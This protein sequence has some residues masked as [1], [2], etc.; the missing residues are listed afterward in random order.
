MQPGSR[1][2]ITRFFGQLHVPV[3]PIMLE[4]DYDDFYRKQR[5]DDEQK[6]THAPAPAGPQFDDAD[7]FR[8]PTPP[9]APADPWAL[10][11]P[12]GPFHHGAPPALPALKDVAKL[13]LHNPFDHYPAGA[14]GDE[15]RIEVDYRSGGDQLD[16]RVIQSNVMANN[17]EFGSKEVT[18]W[19][20]HQIQ[21]ITALD[22][23]AQEQLPAAYAHTTVLSPQSIAD[24]LT[25]LG[26]HSSGTAPDTLQEGRTLDGQTANIDDVLPTAA[27]ANAPTIP[28][29]THEN[30]AVVSTGGNLSANFGGYANEHGVIG[31][32]VVLGDSYKSDAIVQTN[33]LVD[34]SAIE[35][36]TP[37]TTI[38]T[39]GD[40]AS[41]AAD[42]IH[43][44]SDNPY[45]M[46]AF[47]GLHWHV[48]TIQGDYYNVSLAI[49]YNNLSDQDRVSQTATDH[50]KF[51]ETGSN[52]QGNQLVE[53]NLDTTHYDLVIVTGNYYAA[54][55]IFQTNVL[56]NNDLV[57]LN[58][59][60]GGAGH[61]TV[62]T[63]ANWLSNYAQIIDY[64]GAG[65]AMTPEMMAVASALQGGQ[66]SLDASMGLTV[67][68]NGSPDL[69]VLFINGN[70]YDMNV[71]HQT[72]VVNDSD[73]VIQNLSNG[74]S[75]FVT[76]GANSLQNEAVLVNVGPT[77]GEYVA[78]NQYS[79]SVLIQTNIIATGSNVD[80]QP[81]IQT[82]NP[83]QLAPEA[84]AIISH[85]TTPPAPPP[86]D[87]ST[88]PPPTDHTV[89][90]TP[91]PL[92]SVLS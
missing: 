65:H 46:G 92:T 34:Q 36:S 32:L 27:T 40:G 72:N 31:T 68:G 5:P 37:A 70:Y 78:G 66:Q 29:D 77:G 50:Y 41:N 52:E 24:T 49:Q 91:D 42:F 1:S 17:D 9:D 20:S 7:G 23:F 74:E 39:G 8:S 86:P 14:P 55:W 63:G 59:G 28:T 13:P 48:D 83:S 88:A 4:I 35:G 3:D 43:T 54:N 21:D 44:L 81:G 85:D 87:Q 38:Q 15:I 47:A 75:G 82:N 30:M 73:T 10:I 84:A 2:Y 58:A 76:T 33:L 61:E 80:S 53:Y 6:D 90:T 89:H 22:Q 56:L 62:S 71:L 67:P 45:A 79:E 51:V 16:M 60:E 19:P 12:H 26:T 11:N 69:N 18:A 25:E 64:T 57:V